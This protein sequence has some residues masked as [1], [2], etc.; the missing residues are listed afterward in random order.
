MTITTET[1]ETLIKLKERIPP[2]A[3]DAFVRGINE[4]MPSIKSERTVYSALVGGAIGALIDFIPGS[5]FISD[6][7]VTIGAGL[8]AWVGYAKDRKEREQREKVKQMIEGAL[9]DAMAKV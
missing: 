2:N 8:G 9:Q 5:G 6:D 4:R 3:R 1:K 7:W